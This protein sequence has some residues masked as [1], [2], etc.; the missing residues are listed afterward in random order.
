MNSMVR[1]LVFCSFG[2]L[3]SVMVG[4]GDSPEP[5][6]TVTGTVTLDGTPLPSGEILFQSDED[7]KAGRPPAVGKVE[8]GK[9]EVKATV[10]KHKV[11]ISSRKETGPKDETGVAPAT[12]TIPAKYNEKTELTA[13]VKAN[14]SNK[15]DFPLK[16]K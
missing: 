1:P 9:Y 15:F 14:D 13:D 5:T 6:Y 10:G 16:S 7:L 2:F 11:E 4:C 8:N 12:E 3:L